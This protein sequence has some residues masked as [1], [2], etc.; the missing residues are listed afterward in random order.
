MRSMPMGRELIPSPGRIALNQSSC[1]VTRPRYRPLRLSRSPTAGGGKPYT[2]PAGWPTERIGGG[3]RR[4]SASFLT[5]PRQACIFC[6]R[7]KP[8]VTITKEHLFSRWVDDILTPEM[9]GPLA[10]YR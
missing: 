6:E 5:M 9:L 8:L 3:A 7:A 2:E 10:T 4:A 1:A